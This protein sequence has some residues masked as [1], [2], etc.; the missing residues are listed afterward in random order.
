MP[1][2]LH[3]AIPA[4]TVVVPTYNE[5]ENIRPL[6]ARL[7][8]A[9]SG[10]R[11]EAVFV[12]DDSPDGTA[13]EVEALAREDARVRL[14]HRIGRRGLAGACIEGILSSVSS[15]VAVIDADLQ[16]DEGLLPRMYATLAD[17]PSLQL[18]IG[19][20]K[21]AEGSAAGGF[22]VLRRWGSDRANALARRL[23]GIGATDPMSGFFMIRRATFNE[24]AL[25]LQSQGFKLL[26]DM[27]SASRG[28]WR[29]LELPYAFRPREAGQSKLDGAVTLEY[30]GLLVARLTGGLLPIRFILFLMVGLS[31]V[32]VQ[33]GVVRVAMAATGM[34]FALAQPAGVFV[35]MTTNYLLN[36]SVTWRD[37]QLRG[38]AFLRG[39]ASFYAVCAVGAL[40]NVGSADALFSMVKNWVLA[41]LAGAAVGALWNFWASLIVTW[42]AR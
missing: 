28:R 10:I 14:H 17:E 4:L 27:L 22:S 7:D 24:V 6:V 2:T 5:R 29:V 1:D 41:S 31:G 26:A 40:A 19:S 34:R 35:A 12:D 37:R 18:V 20:R 33:L 13:R 30:I 38:A 9:L 25:E 8:A 11:W 36:N 21:V 3:I 23:L 15:L 39:L 32:I 16:H 42:R